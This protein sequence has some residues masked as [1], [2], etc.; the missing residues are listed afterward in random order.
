MRQGIF[1]I[2][3]IIL[4]TSC[5]Q[6]TVSQ[7]EAN[8]T[9]TVLDGS[10]E[11]DTKKIINIAESSLSEFTRLYIATELLFDLDQPYYE[12]NYFLYLIATEKSTQRDTLLAAIN[13]YSCDFDTVESALDDDISREQIVPFYLPISNGKYN[14]TPKSDAEDLFNAYSIIKAQ[15][16]KYSLDG[17]LSDEKVVIVGSPFQL[18]TQSFE[19]IKDGWYDTIIERK[20]NGNWP[21]DFPT[22]WRKMIKTVNLSDYSPEEVAN[23]II[24]MKRSIEPQGDSIA[25]NRRYYQLTEHIENVNEMEMLRTFRYIGSYIA[26]IVIKDQLNEQYVCLSN[27]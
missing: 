2:L 20:A 5:S 27:T 13:A 21:A 11:Y 7:K 25:E 6:D 14:I 1:F 18:G 9:V 10:G 15:Q 17:L 22:D 24:E 19:E 23:I 8:S 3:L 16:L 26:N 4:L 12:H